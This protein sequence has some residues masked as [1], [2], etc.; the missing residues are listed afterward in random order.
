M[1]YLSIIL[2]I[3]CQVPLFLIHKW[4][5]EHAL[6]AQAALPAL[7]VLPQVSA[8]QE[9]AVHTFLIRMH[10]LEW[11]LLTKLI[12]LPYVQLV[13]VI[14]WLAKQPRMLGWIFFSFKTDIVCQVLLG[15]ILVLITIQPLKR[16][17]LLLQMPHPLL[18]PTP[19]SKILSWL[20]MLKS[21]MLRL[22]LS[23]LLSLWLIL[24]DQVSLLYPSL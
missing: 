5:T 2:F 12:H 24:S 22:L 10:I 21:F 11:N 15:Q 16:D 8:L 18:F 23:W 9:T 13:F 6:L 4:Q 19:A 17:M 7:N 1:I 3:K 14:T 20:I